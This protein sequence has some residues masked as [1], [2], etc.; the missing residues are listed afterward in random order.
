MSG[1]TEA[2][3][4]RMVRRHPTAPPA[5]GWIT[6]T[7]EEAGF[8]TWAV[9][10]AVR[11]ALLGVPSVDWDFATRARPEQVQRLFKRTVPIGIDHGTVGVLARDGTLYEVT[12]FRRDVVTDGRHATVD[13]A[14]RV[15]DDLSRRDFTINAIAWHPLRDEL[16]DPFG[17]VHDLERG[18]LRTVGSPVDRFSEDYLRVLRA[19]RFA[20]RFGL[21]IDPPTWEAVRAAHG[22]LGILSP[23][24]V[25][26][27][28]LK[29]LSLDPRPSTVL[30]L[31]AESGVLSE[32]M[33]ELAEQIGAQREGVPV[34]A[35]GYA[36]RVVDAMTR[37]RPLL[38]LAALLQATSARAAAQLL[39]RLR[40][41]NVQSDTVGAL[42]RAGGGPPPTTA[43]SADLRRWL[44]RVGSGR[45]FDLARIWC[46]Q[47]RVERALGVA[48]PLDAAAGWRALRA[49]LRARPPLAVADLAVNGK[50][51]IRYGLK[52]GPRFGRILEAL[53]ER[54]LE[55][56]TLND[57]DVLMAM[58]AE[59]AGAGE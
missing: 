16:L 10:G 52:P 47:E 23:E 28:L 6:R 32:L 43:T 54:V 51:L 38:R 13:F 5:V 3:G 26:E 24:R 57:E 19:L 58:A 4:R 40:F 18:L 41:A 33:P 25:R 12:T 1:A 7:L 35:W 46:A 27:E 9:G 44:S 8:D 11:D 21:S 36:L 55:D 53:L 56:P 30:S 39:V 17:G 50:D 42:V 45:L 22:R 29:V 48:R 20:G 59:L 15:E 37:R 2:V 14:D 31:Y 34:D 49:Q